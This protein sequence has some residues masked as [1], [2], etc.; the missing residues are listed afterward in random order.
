MRRL[1]TAISSRLRERTRFLRPL[2]VF[3]LGLLMATC[4]PALW[5]LAATGPGGF[6][7]VN[8]VSGLSN[9]TAMQFAPDGRLFVCQQ[10]GALRVIKN[11]TLLA[12]SF[13][14]L[15]VDPSGERGLLGVAFDPNF[16][17]NQ[18]VY[19]YYTVPGGGGVTVHNRIQPVHGHGR[20]RAAG[21]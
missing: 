17:T 4:W 8:V 5:G 19:V 10:T 9:P 16:A 1:R 2:R 7:D 20:R 3:Y 13:V 14:S 21:Q 6:Q 15:T 11:G 18:Y 12:A